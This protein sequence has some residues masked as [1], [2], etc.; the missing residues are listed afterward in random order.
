[1]SQSETGDPKG[2]S[3]D[4][5]M[6]FFYICYVRQTPMYPKGACVYISGYNQGTVLGIGAVDRRR[7]ATHGRDG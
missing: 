2:S 5:R 3:A 1:M 7:A 4:E 6:M